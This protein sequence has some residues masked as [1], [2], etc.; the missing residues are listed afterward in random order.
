MLKDRDVQ[1]L[2]FI[3]T[4]HLFIILASTASATLCWSHDD[5]LKIFKSLT[6]ND[7]YT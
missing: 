6:F 4:I 1:N 5:L 3:V 2:D 7:N